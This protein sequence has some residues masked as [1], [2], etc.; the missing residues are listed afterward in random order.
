MFLNCFLFLLLFQLHQAFALAFAPIIG[1]FVTGA[2]VPVAWSL[3]GTEPADGFQLWFSATG[4]SVKLAN[5]APGVTSAVVIFP[6]NGD[7]VF[8]ALS[9]TFLLATSNEVNLATTVISATSTSSASVI[10]GSS[11]TSLESVTSSTPT[12][13]AAAESNPT[14]KSSAITTEA[15]LG[16]IV[17]TLAVIAVIVIASVALFIRRRRRT[18]ASAYPFEAQDME[19]QL[20]KQIT[21]FDPQARLVPPSLPLPP[22]PRGSSLRRP[23]TPSTTVTSSRRQEY[24]NSQL[25]RLDIAQDSGA[26]IPEEG[27]IV[28]GPLSSVPS[29]VTPVSQPVETDPARKSLPLPPIPEDASGSRRAAYL[30]N[31]LAR[32]ERRPSNGASVF[33][34]PL[35]S[36]PSESTAAGRRGSA[37]GPPSSV[38][39]EGTARPYAPS[40]STVGN[41]PIQFVANSPIQFPRRAPP[42]TMSNP[43]APPTRVGPW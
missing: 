15:L 7:G 23:T 28:F 4:S 26:V 12:S 27:S 40:I 14:T 37:F 19:K 38:G 41:S 43:I 13:S 22:P 5:I 32:L 30:A 29:D 35:S 9:G 1:P 17:G 2:Q 6:G 33:M 10:S 34:S 20:A 39:S 11:S 36:V 25:Q 24:L 3:D 21:P 18:A 16:I 8:Q 31:Q 42:S